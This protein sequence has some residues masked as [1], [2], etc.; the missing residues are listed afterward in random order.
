VKSVCTE[1]DLGIGMFSNSAVAP[2]I[3]FVHLQQMARKLL[4]P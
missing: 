2:N 4:R 3:G 1:F